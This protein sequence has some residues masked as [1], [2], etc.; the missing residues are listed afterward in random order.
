MTLY[1]YQERG[2]GDMVQATITL[3]LGEFSC[4]IKE[5]SHNLLEKYLQ[6]S[7]NL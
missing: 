3:D 1:E 2:L 6:K 4:V 7:L 5:K